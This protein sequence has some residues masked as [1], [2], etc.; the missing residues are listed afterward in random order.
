MKLVEIHWRPG[1]R[2]LRQ[3]G[4]ACAGALP[5]VGWFWGASREWIIGLLAAGVVLAG[6]GWV[7]PRLLKP[8]FLALSLVALPI[9]MIL[10]EVAMLAIFFGLFLPIGM[11][12]RLSG[13]DALRLR[14]DKQTK[15]FWLPKKQAR[16][17]ASY[18]RQS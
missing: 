8:L 13:R 15:S 1:N 12:M 4:V 18:Y 10:G 11:V 2:Q 16:D 17:A 5:L 14:Q 6:V 3:F 7:V 9:G